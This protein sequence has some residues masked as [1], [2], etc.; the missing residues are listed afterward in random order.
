MTTPLFDHIHGERTKNIHC[1]KEEKK[2]THTSDDDKKTKRNNT[3][4]YKFVFLVRLIG[5]ICIY[6]NITRMR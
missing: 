4:Q 6:I 5:V 1:T 2:H 3:N